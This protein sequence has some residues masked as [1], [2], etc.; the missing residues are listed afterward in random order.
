MRVL[1]RMRDC[2]LSGDDSVL[3]SV[4]EEICVQVQGEQSLHWAAYDETAYRVVELEVGR[5]PRPVVVALWLETIPGENWLCEQEDQDASPPYCIDEVAEH[6]LGIV[7]RM[8]S[9]WSNRRI[10]AFGGRRRE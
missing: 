3:V 2:L 10:R 9:D 8:A 6:V 5:L 1:D 4:W 7:Y